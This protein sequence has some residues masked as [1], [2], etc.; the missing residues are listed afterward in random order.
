MFESI[1]LPWFISQFHFLRPWWLLAFIP[2]LVIFYWRW[3]QD[4]RDTISQALPEHLRKALTVGERGWAKLLP[5]KLLVL[6]ISLAI[7]VCAGPSWQRE[8]S[9]FGEDKAPLVIVL[10]N[11]ETM[12][13]T[14]L[15]PSRLE[16]AKQKITD[17]L[18]LRAGARTALV[19]YAGSA[20]V[21]VPLTQD[22]SVFLPF[23]TAID[24]QVMPKA[25]KD[26]STMLPLLHSLLA[27]QAGA[28]VLLI[29]D[30]MTAEAVEQYKSY[31]SQHAYQLLIYA[32]GNLQ[33]SVSQALDIDS[34]NAVAKAADAHLVPFSIDNS[35]IEQLNRLI[36]HNMQLNGELAMPWQD[37][38][39]YLLFP[40]ALIMLLWFRK[41]WLVQWCLIG[42][43][44]LGMTGPTPALAE[45]IHVTAQTEQV[46]ENISW[47][48]KA[49]Q[50]WWDLWLTPDQQ[51][52]RL[53][54]QQHYLEAAQ[55]YQQPLNKGIAYYY[56]SEF[57]LAQVAFLQTGSDLGLYYAASALAHQR[58]YVL[59]RKVLLELL[60][61][62][63]LAADLK[64]DAEHNLAAIQALIDEV[65]QMSKSQQGGPEQEES[66]ELGD[67]QPQTGEGADEQTTQD[68]MVV[69][70][71]SAEQILGDK[72]L[73]DKWLKRV[74]A[75]PKQFLRSKFQIQLNQPQVLAPQTNRDASRNNEKVQ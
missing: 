32:A 17:L 44:W 24:P 56:A 57:Q 35:D 66:I 75:D 16:R 38:G 49:L 27:E 21:A 31:F 20:H 62:P 6:S 25:G 45:P 54:N 18:A 2:L 53:F 13:Q 71:L 33:R 43:L 10:D 11:T 59:A 68:K 42:S 30:G 51:G 14:D 46:S 64:V 22:Q 19:V 36:E 1:S 69:E 47:Q 63:Q 74:E 8:P 41:G 73:A 23:L 34:L 40:I 12:L 37:G 72:A 4:N 48:T 65:D 15:A 60:Q 26:A 7:V 5:L 39:Y 3:Q 28:S 9:P 67:D 55:H 29:T 50:W 61:Q 70:Q 52:Q 58:E